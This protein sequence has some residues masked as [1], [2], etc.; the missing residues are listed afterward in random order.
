M[1]ISN[2]H[3]VIRALEPTD[4][5]ILYRW[6]NLP[7]VHAAG[8]S[9]WPVS[10]YVLKKIIQESYLDIYTTKQIRL[11]IAEV[12]TLNL[13][14]TVELFD[15]D[16]LHRR[17]GIGIMIGPEYRQRKI[18]TEALLLFEDYCK[19]TLHLHQ[20]YCNIKASNSASIKLFERV[21]FEKTAEKK[22]WYY[23]NQKRWESEYLY[24]KI[25]DD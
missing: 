12:Q 7:E 18:A 21:G 2:N 13:L 25:L 5:D 16:A 15:F 11:A 6:E 20:L 22:D 17:A 4:V 3:I 10:K 23:T 19:K 8:E 1:I 14:G 24:Q 9:L